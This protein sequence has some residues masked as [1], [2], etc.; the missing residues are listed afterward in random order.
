MMGRTHAATGVLAGLLLGP[1]VGLHGLVEI[2]PFAATCAGYALLPDLDHPGSTATNKLGPITRIASAGLRTISAALYRA[3]KGKRDEHCDGTHRHAS[4][5]VLFA[6]VVGAACWATTTAWGGWAALVWLAFGLLLAYDRLGTPVL[7][8]FGLGA[9]SWLVQADGPVGVG[10]VAVATLDRS[11]G[12]LAVAVSVGC[13]THC[14]GDAL[15]E[16]GCPFLFPVPICGETWYEIRPPAWLRF[17]TG[18]RAEN[19]VVLPLVLLGCLAVILLPQ[20]IEL[21]S[22]AAHS[23]A[24]GGLQ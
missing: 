22:T 5:T 11:A 16:S 17:R 1:A 10:P 12:W 14:L 15:T 24:G 21:F 4:H 3:T 23:T 6:A 7:V 13:L 19:W 8:L 18:T 2:G 9:F 20:V